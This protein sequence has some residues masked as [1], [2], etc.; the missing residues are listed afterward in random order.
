M[1]LEDIQAKNLNLGIK[2]DSKNGTSSY[3][4]GFPNKSKYKTIIQGVQ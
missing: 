2:I 4:F 3:I 1:L